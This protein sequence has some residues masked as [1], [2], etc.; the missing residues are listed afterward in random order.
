MSLLSQKQTTEKPT[1]VLLG[2]IAMIILATFFFAL[3]V[4]LMDS[5]AA[6]HANIAMRMVLTGDYISL[7]DKGSPYLD[8]PHF[9]FWTSALSFRIFGFNAFAYKLPS[10]LFSILALYSTFKLGTGLYN[11]KIGAL[12]VLILT[13]VFAF[14]LGNSDVRMDAI[15]AAAMIFTA[16]QF[17]EYHRSRSWKYL[18]GT[19]AGLSIG[20]MTKGMIGPAVPV[21]AFLFY[22]IEK[23]D[24]K[25]FLDAKI[26]LLIP[27]FFLFS[28]PVLYA[29]YLQF[30]LHPE[31]EIRG[32]TGIS[33]VKFILW[34][35]NFERFDG[36]TWGSDGGKD[37]FF[38]LHTILWAFL[39][40]PIL[41]YFGLAKGISSKIKGHS[42]LE[43]MTMGTLLFLLTIYSFAGFKLP[44]YLNT[45]FPFMAILTAAA[46]VKFEI[47]K[48]LGR[49]HLGL[50][51]LVLVAV[52]FINMYAFPIP[53][54][55]VIG[56]LALSAALIYYLRNVHSTWGF[57][58]LYTASIGAMTNLIMQMNFYPQIL[59]YQGGSALAEKVETLNLPHDSIYYFEMQSFSFDFYSRH[60][61][62]RI[63]VDEIL[64]MAQQPQDLYLY[65][66]EDGLNHIQ[67]M[68]EL[69]T[70]VVAE[71]QAFHVS[72]L[73]AKFLNPETRE[74]AL[75]PHYIIQITK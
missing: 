43:W 27:L 66:N 11:R 21:F 52:I 69:Q 71:K 12:S 65:V 17:F 8:K 7:I 14:V 45:L 34:E 53:F 4:P 73:N 31:L 39:P 23:K 47:P 13:T 75:S 38:F 22:I 5:D 50:I 9:L 61:H 36:E 51:S 20:F 1:A 44:H 70:K 33:G 74:E 72:R 56:V 60:L 64:S 29:Y 16:W 30:D 24:W 57:L 62:P 42:Q 58:V 46:L 55:A 41:F 37:Y 59:E 32:R 26:Y 15:L 10:F 2:L 25:M 49:I 54:Y 48:L 28:S 68:D 3:K 19:A 67:K 63:S 18:I 6:H 40:W 35:Q